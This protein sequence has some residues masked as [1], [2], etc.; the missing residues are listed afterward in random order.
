[1]DQ[2]EPVLLHGW[3]D[4]KKRTDPSRDRFRYNLS[5]LLAERKITQASLA[6]SMEVSRVAVHAWIWGTCFPETSRLIRLAK[7]LN[8]PI[9]ALLEEQAA[10]A[11]DVPSNEEILLLNAFRKLPNSARLNLL[12]DAYEMTLKTKPVV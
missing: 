12:A 3:P 11:P 5:R 8:V 10:A 1:M 9:G 2:Q 7:V 6:R 4:D